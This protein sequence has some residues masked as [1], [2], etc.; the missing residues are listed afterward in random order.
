MDLQSL[1]P[2]SSSQFLMFLKIL[3]VFLDFFVKINTGGVKDILF[4]S[5]PDHSGPLHQHVSID[6]VTHILLK[7]ERYS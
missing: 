5:L 4:S 3:Y 2:I 6:G 1:H 7:Y